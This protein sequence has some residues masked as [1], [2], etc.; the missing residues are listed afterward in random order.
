[1][2]EGKIVGI[3][4]IAQIGG[5]VSKKNRTRLLR[6]FILPGVIDMHVHFRDPGFTERRF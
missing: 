1:M 2:S 4:R 5:A 6:S 3:G